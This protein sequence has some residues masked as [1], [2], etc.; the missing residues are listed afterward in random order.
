M[1]ARGE[2]LVI[3]VEPLPGMI[4]AEAF[5]PARRDWVEERLDSV[6]S[7]ARKHAKDCSRNASIVAS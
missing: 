5:D 2:G 6:Q 4:A 1:N 3:R 7:I